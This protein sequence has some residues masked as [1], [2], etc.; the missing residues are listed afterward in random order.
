MSAESNLVTAPAGWYP[1]PSGLPTPRWWDGTAWGPL[2]Q[3]APPT[4]LFENRVSGPSKLVA[5]LVS[6][7]LALLALFSIPG[8]ALFFGALQ[9]TASAG[10]LLM[11]PGFVAAGLALLAAW[12]R[13]RVQ[14]RNRVRVLVAGLGV[15]VLL[16]VLGAAVGTSP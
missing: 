2:Q 14:P 1:D 5:G 7:P 11:E 9:G 4:Y 13:E 8:I 10:G 6:A 15:S 12:Q 16:V 3:A